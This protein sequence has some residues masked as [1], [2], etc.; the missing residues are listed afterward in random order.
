MNGL[1]GFRLVEV[2][3]WSDAKTLELDEDRQLITADMSLGNLLE[4]IKA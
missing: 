4:V 2:E 3:G 1:K